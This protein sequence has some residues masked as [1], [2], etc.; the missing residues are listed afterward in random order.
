MEAIDVKV[1]YEITKAQSQTIGRFYNFYN[2]SSDKLELSKFLNSIIDS[3]EENSNDLENVIEVIING[4][5]VKEYNVVLTF[6]NASNNK[7][8]IVYTDNQKDQNGN[9][10]I[11]SAIYDTEAPEPFI[12]FLMTNEEWMDV[13]SIM[14]AV[15]L[16][17]K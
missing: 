8:Y 11:Y 16:Y 7:N 17:E 1:Y 4:E 5:V 9:I 13:C 14:D 10:V 3:E 12:G 6:K 2:D 15:F